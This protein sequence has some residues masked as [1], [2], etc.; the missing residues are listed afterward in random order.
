[1]TRFPDGFPEDI[2]ASLIREAMTIAIKEQQKRILR[3]EDELRHRFDR[4]TDFGRMFPFDKKSCEESKAEAFQA[5]EFFRE[6]YDNAEKHFRNIQDERI[7]EYA[8]SLGL[9]AKKP[10]VVNPKKKERNA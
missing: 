2:K 4:T 5:I 7:G 3:N 9:K 8:K 6:I 10:K 1:M